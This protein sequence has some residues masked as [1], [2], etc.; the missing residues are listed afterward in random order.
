MVVAVVLLELLDGHAEPSSSFPQ[1]GACLHL[2]RSRGM[3][4][5]MPHHVLTKACILEDALP[6]GADL[7]GEGLAIMHAVDDE[8]DFLA[9]L[10]QP[11]RVQFGRTRR[12]DSA[13]AHQVWP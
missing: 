12:V 9:L 8:T 10:H 6:S 11:C 13:P 2:P 3:P 7:S 4:E 5:R 1:V